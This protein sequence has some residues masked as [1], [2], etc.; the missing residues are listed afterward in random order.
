MVE[1]ARIRADALDGPG[2][3]KHA[4]L[5]ALEHARCGLSGEVRLRLTLDAN[6]KIASAVVLAGP[7]RLGQCVTAKLIGLTTGA[8]PRG[9]AQTTVD[10]TLRL[11]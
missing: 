4:V 9:R 7:D 5:A 10:L 2:R 6:G 3:L 8:R 11:R 1:V